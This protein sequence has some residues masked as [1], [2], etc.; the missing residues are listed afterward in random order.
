MRLTDFHHLLD[1]FVAD[2]LVTLRCAGTLS[3]IVLVIALPLGHMLALRSVSFGLL[4]VCTILLAS[5]SPA[6]EVKK[7]PLLWVFAI[8]LSAALL[9]LTASPDA[10]S[11]LENIWKEIIKS[12]V[13]FYVAYLFARTCADENTACLPALSSLFMLSG[14]AV[15]AW[16]LHGAWKNVGPVPAL[17]D[18]NTSAITLLPLAALPIYACWRQKL[19]RCTTAIFIVTLALTLIGAALSQSRSFWLVIAVMLVTARLIGDSRRGFHWDRSIIFIGGALCLIALI[20]YV[21]AR[22][23][24]MDLLFFDARSNIYLPVLRRLENSPLTGFG[25]GHES[26]QAW[27]QANMVEAGVFHAHNLILSYA[28]QMGILGLAAVLAIFGGLVQRFFRYV[29]S[30]NPFRASI[31]CIGVAMVAGVFVKNNLDFFFSRHNLLLFFLCCGVL[32]GILEMS[33]EYDTNSSSPQ[34]KTQDIS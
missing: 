7:L 21:V 32:L 30:P 17:G 9:S 14:A 8:W 16:G 31:A 6:Y 10:M 22:W 1:R 11:A 13:V 12:T 29:A 19:G 4:A 2:H 3:L 27:Y 24:G 23:R 26:S 28:E 20:A 18:Y 33:D 5:A 15:I 34:R 25:F